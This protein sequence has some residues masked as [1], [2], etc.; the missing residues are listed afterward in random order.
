MNED[1]A[2]KLLDQGAREQE[3]RSRQMADA[4]RMFLLVANSGGVGLMFGVVTTS[5]T[6][7]SDAKTLVG[8]SLET[9]A[10]TNAD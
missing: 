8:E 6:I 7:T 9:P 5:G 3:D 10:E 2:R 4:T 1:E